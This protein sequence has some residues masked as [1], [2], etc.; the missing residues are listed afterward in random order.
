MIN[1]ADPFDDNIQEACNF[2]SMAFLSKNIAG[3]ITAPNGKCTVN[4]N[5]FGNV[6]FYE[7]T[8]HKGLI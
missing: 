8:K 4:F 2:G 5:I 7:A 1:G 6:D 3:R